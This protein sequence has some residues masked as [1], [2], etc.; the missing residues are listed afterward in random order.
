MPY[1][2]AAA[3]TVAR[4]EGAWLEVVPGAGHFPWFEVPG[5]RA[6]RAHAADVVNE[7]TELLMRHG[8]VAAEE[9]AAELL[10]AAGGD[11]GAARRD[12]RAAADRRAAGVDHRA[13]SSS[14]G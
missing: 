13:R 14:A 6:G 8:F 4:I 3:P 2:E 12:G 11:R 1:A 10:A 9:E 5:L 7:L